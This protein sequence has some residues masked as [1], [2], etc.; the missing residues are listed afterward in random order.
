[1]TTMLSANR[2]DADAVR[3]FHAPAYLF[4]NLQQCSST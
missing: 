3:P 2:R 4:E 1:M